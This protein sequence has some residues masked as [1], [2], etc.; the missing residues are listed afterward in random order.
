[1]TIASPKGSSSERVYAQ[2][3]SRVRAGSKPMSTSDTVAVDVAIDSGIN[4]CRR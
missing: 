3:R 4:T 1:M 2:F